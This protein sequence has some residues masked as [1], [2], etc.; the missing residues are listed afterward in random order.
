MAGRRQGSPLRRI[1][2]AT[3]YNRWNHRITLIKRNRAGQQAE[4]VVIITQQ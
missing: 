4:L 2:A 1:T 3:F